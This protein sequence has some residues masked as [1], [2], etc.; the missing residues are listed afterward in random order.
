MEGIV[1]KLPEEDS[2]AYFHMR[3]LGSQV[4]ASV[5]HQSTVVPSRAYQAEKAES[6]LA[7]VAAHPERLPLP[8]FWCDITC[9]IV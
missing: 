6:L 8:A 2:S 5:S 7:K 1:E 9:F 4:A 3:P